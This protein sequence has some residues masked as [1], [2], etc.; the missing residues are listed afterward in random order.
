[1]QISGII[2]KVINFNIKKKREGEREIKI[3]GGK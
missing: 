3:E 2:Q 1:M